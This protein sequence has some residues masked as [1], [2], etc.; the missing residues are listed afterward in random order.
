M[1]A[2]FKKALPHADPMWVEHGYGTRFQGFQNL[3]RLR[4]RDILL[5]S[6]LYDLYVFEEDGRLYELIRN[7]YQG[8]NLT[9][10]PEL[11][12]VSNGEEAIA[13]AKEERR[14][15]LIITTLHIEDMRAATFAKRAREEGVDIPVVLL[16]FDNRELSEML[17]HKED[18]AFDQ[19]FIWQGDFRLILAIIKHLE[20]HMNVDHDSLL[21]GVQSILLIEDNIRYYS[22][23]LPLIY[24]EIMKQSQRLISEGIN[25][26]HKQL[27]MRARPKI[28]LCNNYEQAWEYYSK[29]HETILGIISDIDFPRNGKPDPVAGLDFAR[30]VKKSHPD[31]PILLHST[32]PDNEP[33]ARAIPASFVL[34]D[35]A[36]LMHELRQFMVEY[37]CFGDFVFH[38]KDGKE[39]GRANDL[40]SLEKALSYVPEESIRFHAERNHFSNWLKARTEFWL[41]HQLR[42]RKVTDFPSIEATRRDLI[43]S[44]REY[45]KLRQKGIITDFKKESYD[46]GSSF[47]RIGGGSLGG[48]ARGLSFVNILINNYNVQDRMEGVHIDIPPAIVV[49]TDIFDQFLDE[50]DL[51][52]FALNCKD[53]A[54]ISR[55]FVEAEKFPEEYLS[56][57]AAFL[58]L[59]HSPIAVRSSSL[60][61]DSH[62][63]PFAGVYKTYMLP[64]SDPDSLIRLTEL[65][66]TIK[67]VYAST[68]FQTSKEYIRATSY[69]LEEEK[70]AVILQRMTG[71]RRGDRF[72]P[73]FS[74]VARSFNFY[75]IEPQRSSDGVV[76]LALGLGKMVVE[77][78]NTIR[79]SPKFPSHAFQYS[80][81]KAAMR[82]MQTEFFALDLN[83][84]TSVEQGP[85]DHFVKR[86]DLQTAEQDGVLSWIASTFSPENDVIYEGTSRDG[87]RLVTFAPMLK[88]NLFPLSEILELLLDM[89]SWGMG[90]PVEIEFAVNLD[91]PPGKPREFA[92][93][94]MRPM[95]LNRELEV[96]NIEAI[97]SKRLICAS[98]RVLGNGV[99]DD[100]YDIVVVDRDRFD[101]SK[102]R[103][104][105]AE[106]NQINQRLSQENRPYVLIGVGRWGTL[107][108][109]LG[110]P[111]TW[112]QISGARAIVEANFKD[113]SVE[114]S[115]GSHFFQNLNSFLVGYFTVRPDE[116]HSFID[117]DWLNRQPA[118]E[119]KTYTRHLR[120]E[121]PIVVKMNGHL[122][123]GIIIKPE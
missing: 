48:K 99:I 3:M 12:R 98:D 40:L 88:N 35:S 32:L 67:R 52:H 44:L 111:V 92:L 53:D 116:N 80:S 64:N 93:L 97:D 79:F 6:S 65:V 37:L 19:I 27:R 63:H 100:L 39:V 55:R 2:K 75:P 18:T 70:M 96:L 104:V 4:I 60:L 115:Q 30:L 90:T 47:S 9:H 1:K 101:R 28:L 103:H 45:R 109:W 74:G 66:K 119:E 86:F 50:N 112:P 85:L 54:E 83:A 58:D 11:T 121:N 51:R 24:L 105:A 15:D 22:S 43:S 76:S 59:V 118:A 108:P 95:V 81:T 68:F 62:N 41:A 102:S 122:N 17:I 46:P 114:P 107:D 87:V 61:E 31:I 20:D 57:L 14:F 106:I 123:K 71:S 34:K 120:F 7:E 78:G 8:L 33:K 10:A 56:N 69:R 113:F 94:Q 110:I 82:N 29:Y 36:T 49:A 23:F 16:A 21:V 5:V 73:T 25:L 42:P 13:L 38:A 26:S 84:T 91:V 89:G 77:G 117:W 72:Y